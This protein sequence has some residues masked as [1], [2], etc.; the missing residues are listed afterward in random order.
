MELSLYPHGRREDQTPIV[1]LI[2]LVFLSLLLIGRFQF[3]KTVFNAHVRFEIGRLRRPI[4]KKIA[5]EQ[6][7]F[8]RPTTRRASSTTPIVFSGA[9]GP[10]LAACAK[11][12]TPRSES[13]VLAL[14]GPRKGGEEQTYR[15][16]L[17]AHIEEDRTGSKLTYAEKEGVERSQERGNGGR[18]VGGRGT[19]RE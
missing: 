16:T 14:Q 19:K 5:G 18:V 15:H 17:K 8:L 4:S 2:L 12:K 3:S 9:K 6:W 7:G 10:P 11:R 1:T 13:H